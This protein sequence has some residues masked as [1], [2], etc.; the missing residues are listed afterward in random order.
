MST[1]IA[2]VLTLHEH[3]AFIQTCSLHVLEGLILNLCLYNWLLVSYLDT[4]NR[5]D[6]AICYRAVLLCYSI[7]GSAQV[8]HEMQLK[9][10]LANQ[11]GEDCLISA[12]TGSGKTL[13]SALSMLLD[14]PARKLVTLTLSLLKRLQMTQE[15]DFNS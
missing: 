14:D 6:K 13:L 4:L 7:T 8:P 10:V 3:L 1:P 2:T 11:K 15:L 9:V 5:D 12:G